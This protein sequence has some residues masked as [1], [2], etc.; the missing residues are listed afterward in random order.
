MSSATKSRES[1]MERVCKEDIDALIGKRF[2][3]LNKGFIMLVDYMGDDSSIVQ[4]ARTSYG[5]GTE[6]LRSEE[7]L[8]RYLLRHQHTTPFEMVELK[9]FAKMPLFV[10]RQW[11]RHR[12]ASINEYS[13][14]YSEMLSD[15]YIPTLKDIHTQS[16]SNRQGRENTGL[17]NNI[18]SEFKRD[19]IETSERSYA[20]YKKYIDAGVAKELARIV[21]PVNFYT[22]WYWKANLH[23]I[24]H[25]LNLRMDPHAQLETRKY[26]DAMAN[27]VK[28][29]VPITY[30][31]FEE[32][33]LEGVSLS[34]KEQNAL[35]SIMEGKKLYK[36]CEDAGLMLRKKDGSRIKNGEGPE[37]LV[38]YYNILMRE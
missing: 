30:K 17:S 24:L 26:A 9:F 19:V 14:R 12:T 16:K 15:Y 8:I 3:V 6:K 37:F 32:F 35:G 25:F 27:I 4:A 5:K 34:S 11:I 23:N 28:K 21:L 2:K 13:G 29:V 20:L 22:Q 36:S 7:G 33:M 10:A 1:K 31:A 38:K 18:K